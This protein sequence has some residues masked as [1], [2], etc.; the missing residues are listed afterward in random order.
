MAEEADTVLLLREIRDIQ[1]AHFER[2]K[3]FTT[4]LLEEQPSVTGAQC[5]TSAYV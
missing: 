3:E 5:S 4:V 1:R 2:Y